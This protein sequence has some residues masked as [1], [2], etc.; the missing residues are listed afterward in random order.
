[1]NLREIS[2]RLAHIIVELM[3][4]APLNK[5][6]LYVYFNELVDLDEQ[7]LPENLAHDLKNIKS[8]FSHPQ[9][10]SLDKLSESELIY[11]AKRIILLQ[12]EVSYQ[13]GLEAASGLSDEKEAYCLS[14]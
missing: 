2:W 7:S 5:K 4:D 6:L 1:M 9:A 14:L 8:L 10:V 3:H 12:S 13:A 11:L